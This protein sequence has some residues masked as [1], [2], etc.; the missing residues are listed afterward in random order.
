M[1]K[2]MNKNDIAIRRGTKKGHNELCEIF[3]LNLGAQGI[4]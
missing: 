1:Y 3:F 2:G 4:V